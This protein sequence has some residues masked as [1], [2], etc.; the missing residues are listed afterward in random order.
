M[1][2]LVRCADAHGALQGADITVW[3]VVDDVGNLIVSTLPAGWPPGSTEG[4]ECVASGISA[5]ADTPLS[6][7]GIRNEYHMDAIRTRLEASR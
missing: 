7:G 5:L 1:K 2:V 4:P 3:Y 6:D